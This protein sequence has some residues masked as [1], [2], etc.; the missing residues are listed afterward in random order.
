MALRAHRVRRLWLAPRSHGE[1]IEEISR[2]AAEQEI[3]IQNL[4]GESVA[5]EDGEIHQ[6]VMAMAVLP[7]PRHDFEVFIDDVL[8]E[9]PYALFL[10]LDGIADPQNFGAVMRTAE[11]AGVNGILIS[12]RR[13]APLSPVAVKASAGAAFSLPLIEVTNLHQCVRHLKESGVWVVAATGEGEVKH[14]DFDWR[15]PI[16]LIMGA[17]GKGVSHLLRQAA[18]VRVAIPL[19][20]VVESLNVSVATGV[21]LFECARQRQG[22][23][24]SR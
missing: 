12:T 17:E 8:S 9:N 23:A 19:L 4:G 11:C 7:S 21:L 1:S 15:R 14:T 18:D 6:G 22:E 20:G 16:A 5:L 3:A 24:K 2:L 10:M 13:R